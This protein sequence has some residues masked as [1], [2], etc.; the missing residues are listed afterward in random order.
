MNTSTTTILFISIAA[1]T[2]LIAVTY[3]FTWSTARQASYE[4]ARQELANKAIAHVVPK[5][6]ERITVVMTESAEELKILVAK[7]KKTTWPERIQERMTSIAK[8]Y[9]RTIAQLESHEINGSA[10]RFLAASISDIQDIWHTM[11]DASTID[12]NNREETLLRRQLSDMKN[13]GFFH[14]MSALQFLSA[15]LML[16]EENQ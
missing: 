12:F 3:A 13:D 15:A 14:V 10:Q 6:H 9:S 7:I 8:L 1:A 16:E 4:Q 5:L 11:F 2:L